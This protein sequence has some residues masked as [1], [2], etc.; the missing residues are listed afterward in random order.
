MKKIEIKIKKELSSEELSRL[1][2]TFKEEV[3]NH[4]DAEF[5]S[6]T[7]AH[8][9]KELTPA[10]F[11]HLFFMTDDKLTLFLIDTPQTTVDTSL[12]SL[13]SECVKTGEAQLVN[14]IRRSP[15]YTPA[16]DNLFD[17]DLKNI[18]LVP[19]YDINES[20]FAFL[21][22][23]IPKKDINQFIQKDIDNI[24]L[25]AKQLSYIK[26]QTIK[27]KPEEE[28]EESLKESQKDKNHTAKPSET[29]SLTNKIKS[30]F[31]GKHKK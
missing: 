8:Y 24:T 10:Q 31:F 30:L 14:D 2:N 26:P 15:L 5:L 27:S 13:I 1:I 16:I 17:Y 6:R 19:L 18:L 7:F 9:V 3:H 22:A 25:L 29:N 28:K 12:K 20:L 21:W 11:V 23:G 4:T